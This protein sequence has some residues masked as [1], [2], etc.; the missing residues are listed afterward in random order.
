MEWLALSIAFVAT[1]YFAIHY[2]GF[3]RGLLFL[4]AGAVVLAA[5]AAIYFWNDSRQTEARRQIASKLISREQI[6]ISNAQLDTSINP[7]A[8]CA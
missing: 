4:A 2:R 7:W 8:K 5:M 1:I 3:R 6:I